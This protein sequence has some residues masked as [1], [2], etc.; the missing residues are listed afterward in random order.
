MVKLGTNQM[1]SIRNHEN[2]FSSTVSLGKSIAMTDYNK[3]FFI[4]LFF[5]SILMVV[6]VNLFNNLLFFIKDDFNLSD[7][8]GWVEFMTLIEIEL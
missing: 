7:L 2:F 4:N 8:L 6:E 1:L 5:H 3:S